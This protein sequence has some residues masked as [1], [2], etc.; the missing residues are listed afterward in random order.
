[1]S[2]EVF[3]LRVIIQGRWKD[4]SRRPARYAGSHGIHLC[5]F[6]CCWQGRVTPDENQAHD[7][8][9]KEKVSA[10]SH[11][12][13]EIIERI[14][15]S[16]CVVLGFFGQRTEK[17]QPLGFTTCIDLDSMCFLLCLNKDWQYSYFSL[18][19][20]SFKANMAAEGVIFVRW[21]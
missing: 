5:S 15:P 3:V 13:V 8:Q 16:A 7:H 2:S 17:Y 19:A 10:G 21:N 9:G 4:S 18:D 20:V 14:N 11:H 12:A 1:M 6:W